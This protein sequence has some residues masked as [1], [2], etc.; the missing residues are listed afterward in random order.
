MT[1][2]IAT[3]RFGRQLSRLPRPA[4]DAVETALAKLA[5]GAGSMK[6]L[7]AHT[8]LLEV[9]VTNHIRLIVELPASGPGLVVRSVG[10]HDVILRRP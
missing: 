1:P 4:R 6:V 7:V 2:I 5:R 10:D 9:R 8:G 3:K